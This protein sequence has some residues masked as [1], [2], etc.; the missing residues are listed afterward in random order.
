MEENL[1]N[2]KKE[3][4]YNKFVLNN[5]YT[6]LAKIYNEQ[7]EQILQPINKIKE[8]IEE[9]VYKNETF[10]ENIQI[11]V[12]FI[13]KIAEIWNTNEIQLTD[14][15]KDILENLKKVYE[16]NFKD[17]EIKYKK[18]YIKLLENGYYPNSKM[19]VPIIKLLDIKN[20][21]QFNNLVC[22]YFDKQ[23]LNEKDKIIG[24]FS[25]YKKVIT[26]I[27]ELYEKQNYRICILS[28]MNLISITFNSNFEN[29]DFNESN[30]ILEKLK[31]LDFVEEKINTYLIL[32]PYLEYEKNKIIFNSRKCPQEYK[33]YPYCRNAIVHGYSV[34]FGN[35]RNCLRWFSVLLNAID[36]IKK[37]NS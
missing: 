16:E 14:K 19:K 32:L 17:V 20:G 37:Q 4:E 28:I 3:N 34:R 21:K 13:S 31:D 27:Y 7:S 25:K 1:E 30:K 26:E 24:E 12:S 8:N 33:K 36:L 18:A 15:I 29:I 35:K 5:Q 11:A 23:I 2:N 6:K 22:E 9:T 10:K